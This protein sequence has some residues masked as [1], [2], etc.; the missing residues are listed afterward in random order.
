M[1]ARGGS[2]STKSSLEKH[3]L[4]EEAKSN[5]ITAAAVLKLQSPL[6]CSQLNTSPGKLHT[7]PPKITAEAEK[8]QTHRLF[9]HIHLIMRTTVSFP[10][11]SQIPDI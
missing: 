10:H 8:I 5:K 6:G 9:T 7:K 1:C 11:T 3:F 4:N 2:H